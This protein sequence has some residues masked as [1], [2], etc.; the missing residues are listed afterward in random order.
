MNGYKYACPS[1]GQHIEYTDGYAG[2]SMPCP[3]CR[4]PLVFPA[5]DPS[6]NAV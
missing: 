5:V 6:L 4:Q 2:Q 1:C 3:M